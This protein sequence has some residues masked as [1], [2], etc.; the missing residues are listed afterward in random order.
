MLP[1]IPK[2]CLYYGHQGID[3]LYIPVHTRY[4]VLC[5]VSYMLDVVLLFTLFVLQVDPP[6]RDS[7]HTL[8]LT[9][10]SWL[11]THSCCYL[12]LL[13]RGS[14]PVE[15]LPARTKELI[16]VARQQRKASSFVIPVSARELVFLYLV[17]DYVRPPRGWDYGTTYRGFSTVLLIVVYLCC[18]CSLHPPP[19]VLR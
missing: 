14:V 10:A 9:A 4:P 11:N 8:R 19:Q 5:T 15:A 16:V 7:A 12:F 1:L 2:C 17:P 6:S 18:L 3:V 13:V